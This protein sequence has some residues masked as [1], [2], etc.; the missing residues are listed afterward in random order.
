MGRTT[1]GTLRLNQDRVG[2]AYEVDLPDT[3][4]GRDLRT[5]VERGDITGAS[6]GF[7]C[8]PDDSEFTQTRSGTLRTVNNV[9]QLLD[10]SAVTYPAYP[11]STCEARHKGGMPEFIRHQFERVME[12]RSSGYGEP[13]WQSPLLTVGCPAGHTVM[14]VP[15]G[16]VKRFTDEALAVRYFN[17]Q[18]RGLG[19][20]TW[21]DV[22]RLIDLVNSKGKNNFRFLFANAY[23]TGPTDYSASIRRRKSLLDSLL[24]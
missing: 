1:A 11:A 24:Q 15:Q 8:A 10:V 13:L 3:Q 12:L 18:Y 20:E 7:T 5:S 16:M 21:D 17:E 14:F 22:V 4:A 19:A 23:S 2:L 9:D 6:F